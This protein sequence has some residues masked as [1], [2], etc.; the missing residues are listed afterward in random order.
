MEPQGLPIL[1]SLQSSAAPDGRDAETISLLTAGEL[2]ATAGGYMLR[3]EEAMDENSAP[4][5]VELLLEDH[6][7]T[8]CRSGDYNV[9]MVFRKGQR[10]EGQYRTPHGS[11]ALALYCTKISYAF[12]PEDGELHLHYQLN[13]NGQFVAMHKLELYYFV[14]KT[15]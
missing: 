12:D 4:T 15:A 3:Y 9:N 8:L 7:V 10:Y 13:I 1:I 11:F 14:K 5:Q 2:F 6:A